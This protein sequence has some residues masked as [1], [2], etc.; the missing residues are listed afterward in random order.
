MENS[1]KII[2]NLILKVSELS[3]ELIALRKDI[4]KVEQTEY[5][6]Y[7]EYKELYTT[8]EIVARTNKIIRD[9]YITEAVRLDKVENYFIG[10]PYKFPYEGI[11]EINFYMKMHYTREI[12]EWALSIMFKGYIDNKLLED[13]E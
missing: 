9:S 3:S 6:F 7:K 11:L 2:N 1:G 12:P 10:R 8:Q 5:K 4:V 13:D